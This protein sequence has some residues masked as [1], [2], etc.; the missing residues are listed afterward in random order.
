MEEPLDSS[1]RVGPTVQ[2]LLID[3]FRRLRNGDR[4]WYE[5]PST[6]TPA[7]LA[8]IRQASLSRV[9]CDN[10]DDI[11]SVFPNAFKMDKSLIECHQVPGMSLLPWKETNC[12]EDEKTRSRRSLKEEEDSNDPSGERVEGLEIIIMKNKL[13]MTKMKRRLNRIYNAMV[14]L[15]S[16]VVAKSHQK[17][18][19]VCIDY[20]GT[21]KDDGDSWLHQDP[22][23]SCARCACT[24]TI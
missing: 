12:Q 5:N 22:S 20:Q 10:G 7:Q 11:Q 21:L 18:D 8:Q 14:K 17:A 9:I 13:E 16:I 6:F 2:C 23:K 1:A 3:Q 19:S 4:F 24:V 15:T